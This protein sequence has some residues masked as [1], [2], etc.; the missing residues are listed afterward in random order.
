VC[1]HGS[2]A[3]SIVVWNLAL[4]KLLGFGTLTGAIAWLASR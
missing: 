4:A 2:G 1:Q 3:M